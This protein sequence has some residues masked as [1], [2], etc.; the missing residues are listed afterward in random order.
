MSRSQRMRAFLKENE[1]FI[2]SASALNTAFLISALGD[3]LWMF[4]IGLFLHQLGGITWIAIHQLV[5]SVAKLVL[6]PVIGSMLDKTNRNKGM[7]AVLFVNNVAISLSALIFFFNL[8]EKYAAESN[9]VKTLYLLFAILFGSVSRVAS[10]AQKTAFTKDWIVV[11]IEKTKGARLSTQ[12]AAM[13]VIDQASSFMTPL[14]AGL[15]LD[16]VSRPVCCLLIIAWNI[17]SWSVEASMLLW[18]YRRIPELA[19]R[20]RSDSVSKEPSIDDTPSPAAAYSAY[21]RQSSFRAAFGLA[22]LYMT[23]LGFD[24]LALS[25]GASQ[26]MSASTLGLF[27]SIGSLLG[28]LG[29]LSY[30]ALERVLGL[31]WTGLIGLM[32][33]NVF[34]NLCSLSIVL[35]GSPFNA[36]GYFSTLTTTKWAEGVRSTIFGGLNS[37]DPS[38]PLPFSE[39][40]PSIIVF[41]VGITLARFGLWIAD[42]SITQIMQETIPERERYSVFGVQT[43]I[44]EFFSVI[45]DIMVIFFPETSSFGVLISISCI[46]VFTGF[47]FYLSYFIKVTCNRSRCRSTKGELNNLKLS[48]QENM[49]NKNLLENSSSTPEV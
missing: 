8:S 15:M 12:N 33:Q 26:G 22:L 49:I 41:F 40:S 34:I 11:I 25:Y 29:A 10:E 28:L 27:R 39:L 30:T 7:Q 32:L 1:T 24:N 17:L 21:F 23:V 20:T 48:E 13:T 2:R 5:D 16:C 19:Q 38:P 46:F 9:W 37:T 18:I 31:L 44:C 4:A 47:S 3:R 6:T 45:K 36:T 43:S 14:I 35:P 42:P